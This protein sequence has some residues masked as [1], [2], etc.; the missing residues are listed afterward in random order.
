MGIS[1]V[2]KSRGDV[3]IVIKALKETLAE[4]GAAATT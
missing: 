2:E 3:D 4:A 1:A